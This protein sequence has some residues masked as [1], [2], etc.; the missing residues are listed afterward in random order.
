MSTIY[1]TIS[2]R[3]NK[4]YNAVSDDGLNV[5]FG[6][7]RYQDYTQTKDDKKRN[8]YIR[9]HVKRENW[10]DETTAGFWSTYL[11]WN[12]PTLKESAEYIQKLL[13]RRVI[14]VI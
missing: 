13:N 8:A 1:I 7:N 2:N 9:R 14:L 5:H 11:L 10:T 4:K 3:K 12:K 6:D